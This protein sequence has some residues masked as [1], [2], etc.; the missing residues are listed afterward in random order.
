M[1][2]YPY[3]G[4]RKR[5]CHIPSI[6]QNFSFLIFPRTIVFPGLLCLNCHLC[7]HCHNFLRSPSIPYRHY[8][9]CHPYHHY[10]LFLPCLHCRLYL[11]FHLGLLLLLRHSP[12]LL[13]PTSTCRQLLG[14]LH[15]LPL[16]LTIWE[17]LQLG[18]R[19]ILQ[20]PQQTRNSSIHKTSSSF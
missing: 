2:P 15:P 18:Y 9:L 7:L 20:L 13:F 4:G 19:I 11:P 14:F 6:P 12:S 8:H 17:I 1:H 5:V 10:Q 16:H 3:V